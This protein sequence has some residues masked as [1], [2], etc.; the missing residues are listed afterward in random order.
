MHIITRD[1]RTAE[2]QDSTKV[3]NRPTKETRHK[4]T[5]KLSMKYGFVSSG[6]IVGFDSYT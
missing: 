2:R 5:N 1:N 4:K 6:L 3:K